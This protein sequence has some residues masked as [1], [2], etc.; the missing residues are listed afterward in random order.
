MGQWEKTLFAEW[1]LIKAQR[2]LLGEAEK[3]IERTIRCSSYRT[4]HSIYPK[5][6]LAFAIN[7]FLFISV[8]SILQAADES[9]HI[10]LG[11]SSAFYEEGQIPTGWRLRKRFG[12]SEGANAKWTVV[13]G[14]PAVMLHSEAALTFLEKEVDIDISEFPVVT[15]KWKV[16]NILQGN[17]ERTKEGDDHP[18]RIFFVFEPDSSKQSFWFRLK[19]F[20]YLDRIH[21]HPMGGR[22]TEYLWSSHLQPNDTI[23]DPGKPWQKLIVIEGGN[24]N[25]GKWLSYKRNLYGDYKKLYQEEPRRLIFIG[26]LNDTDQTGQE[27]VSYVADLVFHGPKSTYQ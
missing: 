12:R 18:I 8:L 9:R 11:L 2:L 14:V 27:A 24:R 22:F 21:G 25:L 19:R 16:E 20:L 15:W 3:M 7:L 23:K 1:T 10:D 13:N 5:D 26:I 4:A 6:V 17:D